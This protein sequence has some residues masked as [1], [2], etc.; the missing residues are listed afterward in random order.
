MKTPILLK[1][2]LLG[3]QLQLHTD[4]MGTI[5]FHFPNSVSSTYQKYF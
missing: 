2:Q 3:S 5:S 4:I 1:A